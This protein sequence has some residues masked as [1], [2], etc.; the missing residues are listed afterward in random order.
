MQHAFLGQ[1][2][3]TVFFVHREIAG[4]VFFARLL[5]L[6]HLAP[7]QMRDHLIGLVVLICRFLARPGNDQRRTSLVDQ[8]RIHLVDDGEVM[9]A[10]HAVL[11]VELHV[12]AQVIEA[13]FVIRPVG[14]VALVVFLALLVVQIVHD[15]ADRQAQKSVNP[16]HPFRV[17]FGQI[18]VHRDDVN[19]LAFERIQ[20]GGRRRHQRL[21]FTGLHFRDPA[22]VQHH[23]ADQLDVEVPHVEHPPAGLPNHREGFDHQIVERSPARQFFPEFN[24]FGRQIDVGKLLHRGLEIVH[25]G[26]NRTHRLDLAL[27]SGAEDFG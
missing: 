9:P 10:L 22:L 26:D 5:A 4:G 24:S 6:D 27:V 17:A 7:L 13:E 8:D 23:A 14:D 1:R 12:V 18:I 25:C 11:Q 20:I 21:A 3:G 19:A 15:N 2:G 16:P